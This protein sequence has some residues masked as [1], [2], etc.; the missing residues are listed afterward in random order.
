MP[1]IKTIKQYRLLDHAKLAA[2]GFC[3]GIADIIP[4]IS[5]GTIAFLLGIYEE[6]IFSVRSFDARFLSSVLRFRWREAL[7]GVA[8]QFVLSVFAGIVAA[9][10]LFAGLISWLN[11]NEPVFLHAFFFG[12]IFATAPIIIRIVKQWTPAKAFALVI[13]A[14]ATYFLVGMIPLE[15][16]EAPWFLFVCG[17]IAISAMI[18]PGIS[19]A[20]ILVLLGKYQYF[21]NAIHQRDLFAIVIFV[22]GVTVGIITFVR[23]LSWLFNRYHDVTVTVTYVPVANVDLTTT[24]TKVNAI[25]DVLEGHGLMA[26]S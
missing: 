26:D 14:A 21:L 12:L 22:S 9:I 17:A 11:A 3:M 13:A 23:F 18:L 6:L 10:L 1:D 19:G 24:E 4:G 8:W 15:T 5:G 7:D 16:P 20:F 2:K 25:L